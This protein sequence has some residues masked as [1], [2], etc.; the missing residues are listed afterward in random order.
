MVAEYF[1]AKEAESQSYFLFLLSCFSLLGKEDICHQC[2]Q[3][4]GRIREKFYG[5]IPPQKDNRAVEAEVE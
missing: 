2:Q 3:K 4:R 5:F 1:T